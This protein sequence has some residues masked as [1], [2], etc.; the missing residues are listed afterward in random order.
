MGV[1]SRR[2][3]AAMSPYWL[4]PAC[5]QVTPTADD[6]LACSLAFGNCLA[7][8]KPPPISS[9]TRLEMAFCGGS[10]RGACDRP[11]IQL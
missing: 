6:L 7:Y 2:M 11:P 1:L 5:R 10:G 8:W 4:C 9:L 3:V